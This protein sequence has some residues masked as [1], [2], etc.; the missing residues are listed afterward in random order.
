[1]NLF[2]IIMEYLTQEPKNREKYL[3]H[4]VKGCDVDPTLIPHIR[5]LEKS[6]E[7]TWAGFLTVQDIKRDVN[8]YLVKAFT[9]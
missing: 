7:A 5:G 4:L 6:V 3:D 1:V 2:E 8:L 9:P